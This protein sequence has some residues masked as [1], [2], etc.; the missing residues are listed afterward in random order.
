MYTEKTK[1]VRYSGTPYE[2]AGRQRT[3]LELHFSY[4]RSMFTVHTLPVRVHT[5][6]IFPELKSRR[7]SITAGRQKVVFNWFGWNLPPHATH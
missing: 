1:G 7:H 2:W 4:Q 3:P 5:I 6:K